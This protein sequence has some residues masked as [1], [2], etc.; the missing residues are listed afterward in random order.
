M[1]SKQT[2]TLR[3]EI[4]SILNGVYYAG[5]NQSE[6]DEYLSSSED[7]DA[8]LAL[9]QKVVDKACENEDDFAGLGNP[10]NQ[11]VIEDITN[12]V[13]AQIRASFKDIVEGK[14]D[15]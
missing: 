15:I 13:K 14:I 1:T 3:A 12:T 7:T 5:S 10:N 11:E 9:F 6:Y 8:I 2:N 4:E